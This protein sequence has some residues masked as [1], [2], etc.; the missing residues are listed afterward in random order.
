MAPAATIVSKEIL[1]RPAAAHPVFQFEGDLLLPDARPDHL[2]DRGEGLLGN[3]RRL[4]DP[5]D[6]PVI[7]DG[8]EKFEILRKGP[9]RRLRKRLLEPQ[10]LL[11]GENGRFETD[12]SDPAPMG[13]LRDPLDPIAEFKDLHTPGLGPRLG[14]IPPVHEEHQPVRTGHQG[15][16]AA[17]ETGQITDI[18]FI[19][20]EQGVRFR[21]FRTQA[22]HPIRAGQKDHAAWPRTLPILSSQRESSAM[23]P[24][25]RCSAASREHPVADFLKQPGRLL[26]LRLLPDDLLQELLGRPEMTLPDI[27]FGEGHRLE[28]GGNP[29]VLFRFPLLVSVPREALR[30]PSTAPGYPGPSA[31]RD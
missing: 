1:F 21:K 23:I 11:H 17:G 28:V 27:E 14:R 22:A 8:P 10:I 6:L 16:V 3:P 20:N 7:L 2:P 18:F 15:P 26:V 12:R 25:C 31:P 24:A 29:G 4:P 19:E 5:V 30:S 9:K 13:R